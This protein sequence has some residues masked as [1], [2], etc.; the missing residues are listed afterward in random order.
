MQPKETH[1]QVKCGPVGCVSV[2]PVEH[3]LESTILLLF[4][5]G[6]IHLT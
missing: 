6:K 4:Y 1:L 2:H 5:C 3:L